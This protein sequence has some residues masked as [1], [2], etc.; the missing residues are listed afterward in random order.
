MA[1]TIVVGVDGSEPGRAALR[2]ALAEARLRSARLLVV[3]VWSFEPSFGGDAFGG[4]YS[5]PLDT[6]E[7]YR[8]LQHEAE[9]FLEQEVA[10]QRP[11]ADGVEVEL[12]V[13]DGR[14][15][16]VLIDAAR[17]ADLLVVGA[18]GHGGFA[19][20]LLGSVSM[21]CAHHAPCPLAIVPPANV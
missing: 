4:G 14:P 12:R 19:G 8:T 15:A 18:R 3:H 13:V 21:Q 6:P 10:S 16:A 1:G 7:T 17:D 20:L 2:F 5:F 9:R 11:V